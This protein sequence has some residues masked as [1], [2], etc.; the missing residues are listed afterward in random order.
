MAN[1]FVVSVADVYLYD[2]CNAAYVAPFLDGGDGTALL[3]T[4][5][6]L[7]VA[8]TLTD[9]SIDTTISNSDTRGG[10]GNQL[11]N[12]YYHSAEMTLNFT[13]AKFNLVAIKALVGDSAYTETGATNI[14]TI[15]ADYVPKS[16][17]AILVAKLAGEAS[18]GCTGIIGS[19]LIRVP[20]AQLDG[21]INISLTADGVATTPFKARALSSDG[22]YAKIYELGLPTVADAYVEVILDVDSFLADVY[23]SPEDEAEY[24]S[25]ADDK[26]YAYDSITGWDSGAA[27]TATPT[28]GTTAPSGTPTIGHTYVRTGFPSASRFTKYTATTTDWS[29]PTL[30]EIGSSPETANMDATAAPSFDAAFSYYQKYEISYA[31]R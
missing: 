11:L 25:I 24:Y 16:V 7:M 10:F 26:L 20:L 13:D 31:A 3:S 15:A 2:K 1:K 8:R 28:N 19:L 4:E 21:A 23:Y 22:I 6:A 14:L 9:S 12:V 29:A 5:T 27:P 17:E 18:N 30:L